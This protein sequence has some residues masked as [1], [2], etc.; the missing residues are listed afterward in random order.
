MTDETEED[1]YDIVG[2]GIDGEDANPN[3]ELAEILSKCEDNEVHVEDDNSFVKIGHGKVCEN[4]MISISD[5][6]EISCKGSLW[7]NKCSLVYT[8][9][10]KLDGDIGEDGSGDPDLDEFLELVGKSSW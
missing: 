5:F 3:T 2:T 4:L 8:V 9:R 1:F 7:C 10:I 6:S